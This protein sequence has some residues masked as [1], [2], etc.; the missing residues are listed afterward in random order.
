ML[1]V[2]HTLSLSHIRGEGKGEGGV[3][4]Y[5]LVTREGRVLSS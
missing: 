1:S 3:T 4:G 5:C 2:P